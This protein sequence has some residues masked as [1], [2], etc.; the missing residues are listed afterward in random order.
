MGC[1]VAS[2]ALRACMWATRA[3]EPRARAARECEELT[4]DAPWGK[5]RASW[6]VPTF[7]I[8]TTIGTRVHIPVSVGKN[9]NLM[10]P[11]MLDEATALSSVLLPSDCEPTT[12]ICTTFTQRGNEE[13]CHGIRGS[14]HAAHHGRLE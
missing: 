7:S 2:T 14:R 11:G 9:S 8:W 13:H 12:H 3:W 5:M 4:L 10:S 6:R 1:K